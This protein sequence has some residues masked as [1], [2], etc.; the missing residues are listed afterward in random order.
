MTNKSMHYVRIVVKANTVLRKG[1][2]AGDFASFL[3]N[4][5]EQEEQHHFKFFFFPFLILRI[6]YLEHIIKIVKS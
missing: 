5:F 6:I 3:T 1:L 4:S 2:S